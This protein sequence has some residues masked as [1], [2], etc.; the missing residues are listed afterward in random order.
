MSGWSRFTAGFTVADRD[1]SLV[2]AICRRMCQVA[3]VDPDGYCHIDGSVGASIPNW[4]DYK[5][6]AEA[7]LDAIDEHYEPW[8]ITSR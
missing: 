8:L 3:S 2:E 6:Y 4:M 1:K 5:I 7:A